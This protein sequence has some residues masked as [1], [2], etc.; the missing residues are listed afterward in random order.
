M[1]RLVFLLEEPSMRVLLDGLLPRILPGLDF[2]CVTHEGKRDLQKSIPRKLK[3]WR[4]PGVRFMVVQDNDGADCKLAKGEIVA[5]CS[6]AGRGDTVIRLACQEL[7]AWYLGDLTALA[8]AY[9]DPDIEADGRRPRYRDPDAIEKPS[10]EVARLAPSFQK[11]SGA[12]RM[13]RL[14]DPRENRS[15]SFGVFLAAVA[16]ISEEMRSEAGER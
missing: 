14:L 7:E 13:A 3:A 4:T 10:K 8:R 11:I 12:R 5:M 9:D 1:S 16:Q 2:L 15:K 6:K